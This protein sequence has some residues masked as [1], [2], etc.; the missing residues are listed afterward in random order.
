MP[1]IVRAARRRP[2]SEA[3][4]NEKCQAG[5]RAPGSCRSETQGKLGW[6]VSQYSLL[7]EVFFFSFR[8]LSFTGSQ[9]P[10]SILTPD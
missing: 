5:A 4:H 2:A 8:I 7:L 3:Q 10:D 9:A 6:K 1:V